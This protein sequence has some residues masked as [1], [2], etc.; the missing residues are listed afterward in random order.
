MNYIPC[1][2]LFYFAVIWAKN[3]VPKR[4][5]NPVY[6]G[7]TTLHAKALWLPQDKKKATAVISD[8]VD[9]CLKSCTTPGIS[10]IISSKSFN[11]DGLPQPSHHPNPIPSNSMRDSRWPLELPPLKKSRSN[12][13]LMKFM[14]ILY[15]TLCLSW[16]CC[17]LPHES[18]WI[19]WEVLS[20]RRWFRG[21]CLFR[22][23]LLARPQFVVW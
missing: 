8:T 17:N 14:L 7:L 10:K 22:G 21:S 19:C 6:F 1:F 4:F 12:T 13:N 20:W 11:C 15:G 23:A 9:S 2:S 5:S 18:M 3:E 16:I